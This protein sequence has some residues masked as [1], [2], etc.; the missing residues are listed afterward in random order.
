MRTMENEF[1]RI[2]IEDRGAQL[3]SVYDKKRGKEL[4]WTAD[5]AFWGYHAPVLFPFVGM[6]NQGKYRYEG[7]AYHVRQ[8]GF[9]RE[10][11]F[12]CVSQTDSSVTHRLAANEVTREKYPFA[13]V[14]EITHTLS[15]RNLTVSWNVQ[16]PSEEKPLYFSIG[17]HPGF[18]VPIAEGEKKEDCYVLFHGKKSLQ[19][20]LVDLSVTAADPD[21]V[22]TME[23][24]DGY[25]KLDRH[26]FDI[27]TFVYENSQVEKVSLCGSDKKPYI[28]VTCPG[29]PYFGLWTKSDEAPFVCLEPWYGRLDDR[30]FTGE[31]PEKTGIQCLAP[32]KSFDASYVISVEEA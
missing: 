27:D 8:H 31:L 16:N 32:K 18:N 1:L 15:G 19:Y 7:K 17:G 28:T 5:P 20:I 4:L 3:C 11:D 29:F 12:V 9:A 22:Y 26:L 21:H 24:D 14:L 10:L 2:G 6:V 25:L 23:L 13:F 30:G